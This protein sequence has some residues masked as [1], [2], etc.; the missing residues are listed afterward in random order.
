MPCAR[1]KRIARAHNYHQERTVPMATAIHQY[2]VAQ[3]TPD[4]QPWIEQVQRLLNSRLSGW[5]VQGDSQPGSD[6]LS[7]RPTAADG[8]ALYPRTSPTE[9]NE[10]TR[11]NSGRSPHC[12]ASPFP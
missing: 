1:G 12:A 9:I 2:T 4:D 5:A 10:K 3:L 6:G 8:A 11:L 7:A